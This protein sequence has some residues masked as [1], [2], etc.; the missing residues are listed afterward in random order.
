MPGPPPKR[1]AE[2]RRRNVPAAGEPETA[3]GAAVVEVPAGDPEWHP[4]AARWYAALERSGHARFYE[5]SDWASAYVVAET[6]SRELRP[7]CVG[8]TPEGEPVW[9]AVPMRGA[10]LNAI[11]KAMGSLMVMEGD[12]RRA[13]LELERPDPSATA[14]PPVSPIDAYRR[15][16]GA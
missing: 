5:P 7:Q 10:S 14:P 9:A 6:M 4:V 8:S 2:R 15:A 3:P 1:A 13:R 12:R 16:L 11:L